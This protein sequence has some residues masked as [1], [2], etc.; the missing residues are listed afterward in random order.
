M[1]LKNRNMFW[2]LNEIERLFIDPDK[3]PWEA[4]AAMMQ[5]MM[6]CAGQKRSGIDQKP[7][8]E[9][10]K[11]LITLNVRDSEMKSPS[12]FL[13]IERSA[14]VKRCVPAVGEYDLKSDQEVY[15][16]GPV[17]L[18]NNVKL[19][20]GVAIIGPAYIGDEVVIGQ[21]C[22]VKESI[23]R[24]R[25]K[26]EY[27]TL[28]AHAVLGSSVF[29]GSNSVL[30][31]RPISRRLV[32]LHDEEGRK[33]KTELSQLGLMAGDGTRIG[34]GAVFVPG[35][36]LSRDKIV[37]PGARILRSGVASDSMVDDDGTSVG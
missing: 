15:I 26:I 1:F 18:G 5:F 19:R 6:D 14:Q 7:T 28:V 9:W 24:N 21:G 34:G 32:T 35:V 29:V 36:I 8:R 12:R 11:D 17:I 2:D 23:L 31:D 33:N 37:L 22:R 16:R 13:T 27:N 10:P 20:K 4:L 25:V 3:Y 30:S